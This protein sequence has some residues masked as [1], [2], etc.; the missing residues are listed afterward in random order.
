MDE[1]V[2]IAGRQLRL[3]L[4]AS[5]T[6][7]ALPHQPLDGR[8][9]RVLAGSAA[10]APS[11]ELL[12][13]CR[14]ELTHAHRVSSPLRAANVHRT[15]F[16]NLSPDR[17]AHRT[18]DQ[19]GVRDFSPPAHPGRRRSSPSPAERVQLQSI[20]PAPQPGNDDHV[21]AY[22][23]LRRAIGCRLSS[24]CCSTIAASSAPVR[25][26]SSIRSGFSV[27][28]VEEVRGKRHE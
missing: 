19:I 16:G 25:C 14:D 20:R 12:A 11:V 8:A 24:W 10:S 4:Q 15:V 9:E 7:T 5:G 26:R 28:L 1:M 27:R 3:L 6:W 13:H 22:G 2:E 23:P 21:H 17:H 18:A